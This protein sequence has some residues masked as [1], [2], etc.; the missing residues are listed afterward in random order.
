MDSTA[1]SWR[2]SAASAA[3]PL[4]A[5]AVLCVGAAAGELIARSATVR[6]YLPAPSVG[7]PSRLL[8]VQRAGLA[9]LSET[10]GGVDCIFLGNSL[11]LFG[12]DPAVFAQEFAARTDTPARCFNFGVSAV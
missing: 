7:S 5:V 9:A 12:V 4:L 6:G 8:E 3:T 2:V 10:E 11:V 1:R